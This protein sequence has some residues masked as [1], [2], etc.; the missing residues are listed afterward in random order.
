LS[1]CEALNRRLGIQSKI[2]PRDVWKP[3]W[4]AGLSGGYD[5]VA[6]ANALHW[7]DV[8]RVAELFRDV[9]QLLR[10]GGVF[11]FLEPASF[12]AKFAAGFL[13]WKM[14]QAN[15]YDPETWERFWSRA[16]ALLG[17]DHTQLLGTRDPNLIGDDGI[18]VS[19]WVRLLENA[20]F[21]S[22]DLLSRNAEKLV[23]ASS[24]P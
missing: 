8:R 20:G 9:I 5:V 1:L 7:F 23:V 17:Y 3:D 11:V 2:F 24:K 15:R 22:V 12:E 18:P 6:T 10:R 14:K 16:N 4:T 19:Q 21:Q 13:E